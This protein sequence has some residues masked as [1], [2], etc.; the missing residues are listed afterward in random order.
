[1]FP[2][3]GLGTRAAKLQLGEL[4]REARASVLDSQ[5]KSLGISKQFT[6]QK[7]PNRRMTASPYPPYKNAFSGGSA[8]E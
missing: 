6:H 3:S 5:A 4:R 2:S 7:Q 1:L 8:D